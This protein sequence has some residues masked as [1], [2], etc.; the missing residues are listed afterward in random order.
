M[1]LFFFRGKI[2]TRWAT[3][4][5]NERR[6]PGTTWG[7]RYPHQ[8]MVFFIAH[9]GIPIWTPNCLPDLTG[10]NPQILSRETL[11][12]PRKP[13]DFDAYARCA[14]GRACYLFQ[15]A[16]LVKHHSWWRL[17]GICRGSQRVIME[18]HRE[19]LQ[20][21]LTKS[22]NIPSLKLTVRP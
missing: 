9:L 6:W 14:N 12:N 7:R 11:E 13:D 21:L 16:S 20:E 4:L 1:L 19:H 10:L 17:K 3:R 15:N 18:Q 2:G 5:K 8:G 22:N